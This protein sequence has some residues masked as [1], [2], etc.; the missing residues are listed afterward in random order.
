[1]KDP[2]DLDRRS[3]SSSR[4]RL[5]ISLAADLVAF[6]VLV[7]EGWVDDWRVLL[8]FGVIVGSLGVMHADYLLAWLGR[9]VSKLV[10]YD[11]LYTAYR[12]A[13]GKSAQAEARLFLHLKKP[14]V[15][16][17]GT[18]VRDDRVHLLLAS[19][20]VDGETISLGNRLAIINETRVEI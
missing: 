20:S 19:T 16:V 17:L 12:T 1:M 10:L 13:E 15:P 6:V 3:Y 7:E 8:I 2:F 11:R 5:A 18:I 4:I 9:Q 14:I